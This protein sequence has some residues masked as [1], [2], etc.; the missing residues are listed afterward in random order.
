VG[1][2]NL[3]EKLGDYLRTK[4]DLEDAAAQTCHSLEEGGINARSRCDKRCQPRSFSLNTLFRYKHDRYL[5]PGCSSS[6]GGRIL[7]GKRGRWRHIRSC[8]LCLICRLP[9]LTRSEPGLKRM[10]YLWH[11]QKDAV[12]PG[13]NLR[14]DQQDVSL[15]PW[16]MV[17]PARERDQVPSA[18]RSL[19]PATSE[20]A[21]DSGLSSMKASYSWFPLQI[22]V[23]C[24]PKSSLGR[25][26]RKTRHLPHQ[27]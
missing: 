13:H 14:S 1:T 4:G 10:L 16:R 5:L 3:R 23:Q 27:T 17:V 18:R 7:E 8:K 22:I 2:C 24:L 20:L 11:E 15:L 12:V 26:S 21:Q 9:Q 19:C 6:E 25:S